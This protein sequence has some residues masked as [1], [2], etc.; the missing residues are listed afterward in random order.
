MTENQ[1]AAYILA[2]LRPKPGRSTVAILGPVGELSFTSRRQNVPQ[3]PYKMLRDHK[4]GHLL[5]GNE[6]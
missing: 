5:F 1:K 6:Q 2:D 4:A 3:N